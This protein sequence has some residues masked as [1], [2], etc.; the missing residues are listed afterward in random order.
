MTELLKQ[1][2]AIPSPTFKEQEIIAFI[3]KWINQ[4]S[5][6]YKD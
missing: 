1:L 2:L 6:R 4:K 5:L 3:K